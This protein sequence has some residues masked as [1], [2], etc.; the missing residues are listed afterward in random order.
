MSYQ[1][2]VFN[3]FL[4]KPS[5]LGNWLNTKFPGVASLKLHLLL[6]VNASC[7]LIGHCEKSDQV[8]KD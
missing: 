2:Y 7:L 6:V 3:Y 1:Y 8:A 4:N 5:V